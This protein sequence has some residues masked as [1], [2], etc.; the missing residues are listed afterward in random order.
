M[1]EHQGLQNYT[2]GQRRGMGIA[3]PEP[4]YVIELDYQNNRLLVGER[5]EIYGNRLQA[6]SINWL[7]EPPSQSLKI[8]CQIRYRHQP[9]PAILT[10]LTDGRVEVEFESPQ[11][12]I[13]PGQGAAFYSGDRLLGGGFIKC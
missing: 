11:Y 6:E 3:H 2:V 10:P 8:E 7:I 13:T 1:G 12:A 4:L 5:E 9:A